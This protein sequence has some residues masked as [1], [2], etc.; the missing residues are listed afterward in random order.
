MECLSREVDKVIRSKKI[1]R[2]VDLER[3]EKAAA[4]LASKLCAD[5][6]RAMEV[7]TV[8]AIEATEM[9]FRSIMKR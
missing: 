9:A 3:L 6:A 4:A 5:L 7:D 1:G 8:E 2:Q